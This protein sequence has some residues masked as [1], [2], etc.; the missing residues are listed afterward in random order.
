MAIGERIRFIRNLRGMTQKYLG[1]AIGFTE[2]TSDVRMAQY[3]AGARTPKEKMIEDLANVLEVCPQA[4]TIPDIDNYIGLAHT[5]FTLE[6]LYGIKIEN[7]D[8]QLSL[9]LDKE[10]KSYLH[11][12]DIFNAWSNESEKLKSG[13]ISKEEYDQWRYNYPRMEAARTKEHLDALRAEKN[14]TSNQE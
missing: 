5:L 11:M 13:E 1:M 12:L 4:L 9:I 6:D 10:S 7:N 8:G 2:K 14:N 3:E